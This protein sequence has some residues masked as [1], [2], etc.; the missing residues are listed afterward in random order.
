MSRF[1]FSPFVVNSLADPKVS[2]VRPQELFV[3]VNGNV[4][5]KKLNNTIIPLI[6]VLPS[7]I[8]D[9]SQI[10]NLPSTL[11]DFNILL[12]ELDKLIEKENIQVLL[13]EDFNKNNLDY[14]YLNNQSN[15]SI[16]NRANLNS[17]NLEK[18]K[19]HIAF[20]G[21]TS[22]INFGKDINNKKTFSVVDGTLKL[23]IEFFIYDSASTSQEVIDYSN[24][25]LI[26]GMTNSPT[27]SNINTLQGSFFE[28]DTTNNEFLLVNISNTLNQSTLS[29]GI[30]IESNT[31]YWL[32]LEMSSLSTKFFINNT[33]VG[34]LTTNINNNYLNPNI[35]A[36]SIPSTNFLGISKLALKQLFSNQTVNEF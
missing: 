9:F 25:R 13:K 28:I 19:S 30:E 6:N 2:G 4:F 34:E 5:F 14:T 29:T 31:L 12:T 15:I 36:Y 3:D 11:E 23:G 22:G 35:F 10:T 18:V 24:N 20:N 32:V 26:L 16:L 17:R 8:F 33:L 1:I 27:L 7:P 21:N